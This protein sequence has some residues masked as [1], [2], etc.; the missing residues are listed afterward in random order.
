[1]GTKN[2]PP[3]DLSDEALTYVVRL[4]S[5]SAEKKDWDDFRRWRQTSPD[6]EAAATEAETLWNAASDLSRD[7][8]TGRIRPKRQKAPSRRKILGLAGAGIA[9]AG[10]LWSLNVFRPLTGDHVTGIAET[11][12]ITLPDG[13]RAFLNALSA[14][15]VDFTSERRLLELVEGQAYFEVAGGRA[16]PF[17]VRVGAV[18]ATAL[19][20]AFDVNR[21]LPDGEVA[22]AVTEHSVRVASVADQSIVVK[23]GERVIIADDGRLGS[24]SAEDRAVAIAWQSGQYI[25]EDRPL[26]E[27]VAA[28]SAYYRGWIIIDDARLREL[29]VNAVLDLKNPD[30][31]IAALTAGLAIR[32]RRISPLIIMISG[33]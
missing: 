25:A 18:T 21:N 28:L 19:G 13:S 9:V 5:G 33:A 24:V 16:Q 27:V 20:T 15:N 8:K 23:E 1:M 6:H 29:R 2:Y 14:I 4:H 32:M 11:R 12:L 26:G 3:R 31:S 22:I 10:G 30:A 17:E 7:P